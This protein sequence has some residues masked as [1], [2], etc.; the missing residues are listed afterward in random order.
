MIAMAQRVNLRAI[1]LLS[2][3]GIV[4]G[5]AAILIQA[6][7]LPISACEILRLLDFA[8]GGRGHENRA[9]MSE[10]QAGT[11]DVG[12]LFRAVELLQLSERITNEL[13]ASENARGLV[14]FPGFA[15]G[16]IDPVILGVLGMQ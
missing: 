5:N 4:V 7:N 16:E 6:K 1:A 13:R 15:E 3:E 2:K 11:A 9:V 12:P 8:S 14:P 10:S